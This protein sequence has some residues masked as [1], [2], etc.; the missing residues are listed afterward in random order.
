MRH[1]TDTVFSPPGN[2]DS[3][4]PIPAQAGAVP[5]VNPLAAVYITYCYPQR[6]QYG[7]CCNSFDSFQSAHSLIAE[8]VEN[9]YLVTIAKS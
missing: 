4:L 9:G 3:A 1:T 7:I 8:L 6:S 5:V 2:S